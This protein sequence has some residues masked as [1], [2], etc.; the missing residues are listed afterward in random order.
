MAMI[1]FSSSLPAGE[2]YRSLSLIGSRGAA[3]ADDQRDRNLLFRGD[4][5]RATA[6]DSD[7]SAL[8]PMIEDFV[9]AVDGGRSADVDTCA[10]TA[11]QEL[12]GRLLA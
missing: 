10:F 7:F 3:Y 1:D 4:A 6:P 2:G 11:A 8:Q 12:S 9:S 5:P